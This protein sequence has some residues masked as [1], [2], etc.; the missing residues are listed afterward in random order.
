MAERGSA[1]AG[2]PRRFAAQL[3]CRRGPG[4]FPWPAIFPMSVN[5]SSRQVPWTLAVLGVLAFALLAVRFSPNWIAFQRIVREA[6]AE[7]ESPAHLAAI[8]RAGRS[9]HSER[10]LHVIRQAHG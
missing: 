10:G 2:G 6:K 1:E 4:P 7:A 5:P 9:G 3:L 8:D